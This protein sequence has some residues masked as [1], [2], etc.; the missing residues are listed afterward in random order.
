MIAFWIAAVALIIVGYVFFIPVFL[1]K[2]RTETLSRAKLN[3]LLHQ[4]RQQE[5]AREGAAPEDLE[6]LAA[7]SERNLLGDLETTR[8]HEAKSPDTGR[9]LVVYALVS[10]PIFAFS[11]YLALGRPDLAGQIPTAAT[12]ANAESEQEMR[13]DVRTSIEKLAERLKEKPDDLEGWVLLGRSLQST[14][15][16]DKA[17]QA[18]EF[19]LKQAPDNLDIKAMYAEALVDANQGSVEGKPS[20]IIQEILAKDPNNKGGLW[21]AGVAAVQ[22][23][24]T[25]KAV[26]YWEKLKSQFAP[27]SDESRQISKYIA[28]AQGKPTEPDAPRATAAEQAGQPGKSIRVKV[29]LSDAVKAQAAP[30]DSLFIFARAA[31]GPPMPLAVV[32]KKA[33]DL[34]VEVTLD[35]SM[36][37]MP[38]MSIASFDRLIIGARIS[39]TG[40]PTP[41]PGDLQGLTQP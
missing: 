12:P 18:Y 17:V 33:S 37:M 4:Q 16:A 10:L 2:N 31:E 36:S 5:L 25:A 11:F 39:K 20:E 7:E 30:D 41:T 35:D 24:D 8:E 14:G 1:G 28:Q 3:L 9:T 27:D 26:E 40:R 34:P 13:D 38:G 21:M 29:T 32:R 19:A 22:R 23:K 15:Q 6:R